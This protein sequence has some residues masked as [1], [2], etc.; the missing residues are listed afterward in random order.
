MQ[1]ASCVCVAS[2]IIWS[3]YE[4]GAAKLRIKGVL[5]AGTPV[6]WEAAGATVELGASLSQCNSPPACV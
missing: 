2:L 4:F 1:H 6:V 5:T 3:V